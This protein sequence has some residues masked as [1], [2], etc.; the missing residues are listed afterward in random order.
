MLVIFL[1]I[2]CFLKSNPLSKM[3][4]KLSC[5]YS[6]VILNDISEWKNYFLECNWIYL[7]PTFMCWICYVKNTI[8]ISFWQWYMVKYPNSLCDSM[9]E[10]VKRSRRKERNVA[11]YLNSFWLLT[12]K[13][14]FMVCWTMTALLLK[15]E[16]EKIIPL[17]PISL[18]QCTLNLAENCVLLLLLP[19]G[20]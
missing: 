19:S 5:V 2:K 17:W 12:A 10:F 13:A 11:E 6:G 14:D 20:R 18:N 9:C 1:W 8:N 4:L 16:K 15:K 7:K 3:L